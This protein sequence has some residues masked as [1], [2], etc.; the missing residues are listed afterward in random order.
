MTPC[1]LRKST[2]FPSLQIHFAFVI[3]AFADPP[4]C[5]FMFWKWF[6]AQSRRSL[7]CGPRNVYSVMGTMLFYRQPAFGKCLTAFSISLNPQCQMFPHLARERG[8]L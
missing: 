3:H 7:I 2:A 8:T 1:F 5:A 4:N 6:F